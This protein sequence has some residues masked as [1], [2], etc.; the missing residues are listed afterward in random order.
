M[1]VKL[2]TA[3]MVSLGCALFATLTSIEL[4]YWK[5]IIRADGGALWGVENASEAHMSTR[6][7]RDRQ[8]RCVAA[9]A[10]GRSKSYNLKR[11]PAADSL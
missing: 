9:F 1:P 2:V 4:P 5:C 6:W 8:C 10:K 7:R 11:N 3:A